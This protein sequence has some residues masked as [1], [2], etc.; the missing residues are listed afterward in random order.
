MKTK[1]P[2]LGNPLSL[3]CPFSPSPSHSL[4]CF[5][6]QASRI[7]LPTFCCCNN[8]GNKAATAYQRLRLAS[9]DNVAEAALGKESRA[10]SAYVACQF[11]SSATFLPPTTCNIMRQQGTA[12]HAALIQD[13][14]AT[15]S[16]TLCE[17]G[18]YGHFCFCPK[19]KQ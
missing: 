18:V 11:K 3:A 4:A 1:W 10:L 8:C 17:I 6:C 5:V 2:S 15:P 13:L 7:C 19:K 14:A 12:I 9:G 16:L